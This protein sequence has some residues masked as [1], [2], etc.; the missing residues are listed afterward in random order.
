MQNVEKLRQF[1]DACR[2]HESSK[3]RN[4]VVSGFCEL[5]AVLFRIHDHAAKFQQREFVI[6]AGIAHLRKKHRP[7]VLQFNNQRGNPHDGARENDA[8]Q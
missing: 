8:D 6:V 1:V 4:A 7:A 3:R 2:A 5:R